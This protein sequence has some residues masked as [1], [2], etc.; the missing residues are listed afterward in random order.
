MPT[1]RNKGGMQ[2][3]IPAGNGDASGEYADDSGSNKH[4]TN[5]SKNK[6]NENSQVKQNETNVEKSQT[7]DE[8]KQ[9]NEK[10]K[11]IEERK[12]NLRK[13]I[14]GKFKGS[15][16]VSKQM[17]DK[18]LEQTSDEEISFLDDFY[19]N[20]E[21]L[22]IVEGSA[23]RNNAGC[24][25]KA[26]SEI[27][28]V[29]G[30]ATTDSHTLSHET[31]HA[32]DSYIF[33]QL[34]EKQ[35]SFGDT[36]WA[37]ISWKDSDGKT[38]A[39][40]L[41][42]ES[43]IGGRETVIKGWKISSVLKHKIDKTKAGELGSVL[44]KAYNEFG[45]SIVEKE[46][47]IK[48]YSKIKQDYEELNRN[49]KEINEA[50]SQNKD[51]NYY[52]ALKESVHREVMQ[53][54]IEYGDSERAKGH[55]SIIYANSP[56]VQDARR[57]YDTVYDKFREVEKNAK[58]E[59]FNN[60]LIQKGYDAN[61]VKK[62]LDQD[63]LPFRI[64]KNIINGFGGICGDLADCGMPFKSVYSTNGHGSSYFKQGENNLALELF[65]NMY[66]TYREKDQTKYNCIK[67]AMPKTTQKFENMLKALK[68][69]ISK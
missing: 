54:E 64:T 18:L 62:F 23:G 66:D 52:R 16:D 51:Y 13:T 2:E 9:T 43:G 33:D 61:Q 59:V 67:K 47:G 32:I 17:V 60:L 3:Y 55:Y 21:K 50:L 37:T 40:M 19:K 27:R 30:Y 15:D 49:Y 26:G 7:K 4:F 58:R 41:D 6:S 57:R 14:T 63:Y 29:S 11:T 48:D 53:A 5:F 39:D 20:N 69:K 34:C 24:F 12:A 28:V 45:D 31:G 36:N 1:K 65:A 38:F 68:E 35:D 56:E 10:P 25:F 8:S 22:H 42:E 46:L 44:S